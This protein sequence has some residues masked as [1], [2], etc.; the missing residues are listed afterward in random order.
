M[1]VSPGLQTQ[2]S[3]NF[4][5]VSRLVNYIKYIDGHWLHTSVVKHL[6]QKSTVFL[7]N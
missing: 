3:I 1:Q 2:A 7:D 6:L 5:L 4:R